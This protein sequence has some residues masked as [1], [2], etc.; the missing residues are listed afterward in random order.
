M[1]KFY[2]S[3]LCIVFALGLATQAFSASG[4]SP[5]TARIFET[6]S[7]VGSLTFTLSST[8][9]W[10]AASNGITDP[11]GTCL[12]TG[13]KDVNYWFCY[14]ATADD[15]SIIFNFLKPG[16]GGSIA[17]CAI[18][19]Y[20]A[21]SCSGPFT[22]VT[23]QNNAS[24]GNASTSSITVT[25]GTT[26]YVRL[27]DASGNGSG[28]TFQV[29]VSIT[30]NAT[31]QS[32]CNPHVIPSLPYSY[33]GNSLCNGN[34]VAANCASKTAGVSGTG[35][36]FFFKYT[37]PGNEYVSVNLSGLNSN[38]TQGLVVSNPVASCSEVKT[39]YALSSANGTFPGGITGTTG[40]SSALCRTLYLSSAGDYYF[41]IDASSSRGG[42]FTLSLNSY[43]PSSTTDACSWAQPILPNVISYTIDNCSYTQD[44]TPAEPGDPLTAP[45]GP[46]GCGFTSENSKWLSFIA[47]TPAPPEIVVTVAGISC[48]SPDYGNSAGIEMGIFTGTCGG[49]WTKVGSCQSAASGTLT[50]SIISP[51]A[52][53]Q[54]YVVVDGV[55][56]SICS[57]EISATNVTALPIT[58]VSFEAVF[59][60]SSVD[61]T[62]KS[63]SETG[64]DYYTVERSYNGVSFEPLSIVDAAGAGS[65][66]HAYVTTDENVQPGIIYY[67][68]QQ[69]DMDGNSSYSK[70]VSVEVPGKEE[71]IAIQVAPNPASNVVKITLSGR[72]EG[73]IL[74]ITDT[75]GKLVEQREVAGVNDVSV[76]LDDY[77]AG[78]YW[79]SLYS[80]EKVIRAK[81]LKTN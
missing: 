5:C 80:N 41:I 22:S 58:V 17:D 40:T 25:A 69:T 76:S 2:Q 24:D 62:W 3:L 35:E 31:G 12:G 52:G 4:D 28:N 75:F 19:V 15:Q 61:L 81:L 18:Q 47:E 10:I 20:S 26:Y 16:G 44:H 36:D 71:K 55:A 8:G 38:I 59:N 56:G 64:N 34:S 27:F 60:G 79:V 37:S 53:Q 39:C 77:T 29:S 54:Y 33:S 73:S 6:C 63:A 57:F 65:Q 9:N 70:I 48:S 67:R 11:V 42:P 50:Q 7:S 78:V 23:C 49:A 45:A 13:S 46:S 21:S 1:R 74:Q 32:A 30:K 14:T 66:G 51:P 43:V 72:A 68:L